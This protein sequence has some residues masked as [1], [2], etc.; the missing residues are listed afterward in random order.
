MNC[1]G[2]VGKS[3]SGKSTFSQY[4]QVEL[5]QSELIHGD[6]IMQEIILSEKDLD[7]FNGEHDKSSIIKQFILPK[8]KTNLMNKIEELLSLNQNTVIIL[9]WYRLPE[10]TDIWQMC[11]TKILVKP[12]NENL[13]LHHIN[14]RKKVTSRD[15]A[16]RDK[17][18]NHD[19]FLYDEIII[20]GYDNSLVESAKR[21][22]KKIINNEIGRCQRT[23]SGLA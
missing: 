10:N 1:I 17:I 14:Q 11:K 13:R 23:T 21:M 19:D 20:N 18:I 22:A 15:L 5:P 16:I 12:I 7:L 6:S 3:G 8:V 4:L 2:I 9:D